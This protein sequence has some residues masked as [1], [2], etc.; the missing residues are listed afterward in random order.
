LR[1]SIKYKVDD[2]LRPG[3]LLDR[4]PSSRVPAYRDM[5]PSRASRDRGR[6]ADRLRDG[7]RFAAAGIHVTLVEAERIGRGSTS[8]VAGWISE[9][10]GASF[11]EVEKITGRRMARHAFHAWRRAALD[12]SALLRRLDIACHLEPH[13]ALTV[14][15]TPEQ[16]ARLKREQKARLAAGLET[17]AFNARA[18]S[19]EVA[20][21][22]AFALRH[23]CGGATARSVSS[24]PG[25]R[26]Q[27]RP[28]L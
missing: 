28:R 25:W 1:L 5:G 24:V 17:P 19:G 2:S 21:D 10:P 8:A 13:S 22:A 3:A 26:R 11:V 14:G 7:L 16:I 9:D 12:F 20:L 15:S 4:F 23:S 27:R 6:R 18:V